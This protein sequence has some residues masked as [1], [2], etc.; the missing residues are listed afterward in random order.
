VAASSSYALPRVGQEA[1]WLRSPSWDLTFVSLSAV[2]VPLPYLIYQLLLA[3]GLG[4]G[5]SASVVDLVVTLFIGGPHMYA[6]F[7]RTI[8]DPA[9]RLHHR[10]FVASSILIPIGVVVV[11][12]HAFPVL[13]TVFFFWASVHV[14]HQITFLVECYNRRGVRPLSLSDRLIEYAV[15]L[16]SPYPI[17]CYR[18]VNGTFE[19]SGVTIRL[20]EPLARPELVYLVFATFGAALVLFLAKTA[21]ELARGQ[22][23]GPKLLL[24][25]LTV[26]ASFFLPALDR[27][28]AAF[29]GFNAWHSFQYLGLTWYANRLA[30]ERAEA[31][32]GLRR[33]ISG[34]NDGWRF[35]GLLVLCTVAAGA[36]VGVLLLL[37]QPLGL[38]PEQPYYL[39]ILSFLLVHYY[40][41]HVLFT[42]PEAIVAG[43]REPAAA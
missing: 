35:Y 15:V 37:R 4:T 28:D 7:T 5:N 42:R 9:F 17:A 41:D 31:T 20:P 6:T 18:L 19:I 27:L 8:A 43:E 29:Q 23:H 24:I 22:V 25:G 3:L 36:V 40:H 1:A 21:R 16:T 13:L 11:G 14:L 10:R 12:Y 26:L 33:A 2:L 34:P 32:S 38:S 30:A 39:T